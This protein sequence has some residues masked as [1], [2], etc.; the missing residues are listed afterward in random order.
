[1]FMNDNDLL[2][3][4]VARNTRP[5]I[6]FIV[7]PF[8]VVFLLA[9]LLCASAWA[10]PRSDASAPNTADYIVAVV[11]QELVTNGELQARIDRVRDDAARNGS[12]LPPPDELR[13]RALDALIDE[14]VQVTNARE[15]GPKLDEVDIDRAVANVATQNQMTLTQLRARLKQQGLSFATFRNNVKDQMLVERV[16]EREV[17]SRIRITDADVDAL[18]QQ[19]MAAAKGS[20]DLQIAQILTAVPDGAA[21]NVVAEKRAKAEA[22]LARVEA[23]TDFATVAHE[24]SDDTNRANGGDIGMRPADRLPDVFVAAVRDLEPGQVTTTLLQTGAGFHILKLVKRE[25]ASAFRVTQTHVRHILLR[26]SPE[27]SPE[28]A[29]RRLAEYRRQI[30]AGG[31]TFERVAQQVSEDA[32]APGGGDL[33]WVSPGSLVP[34]FETAMDA[35]PVDG[36]SDPVVSRFGVHLIQ[37]LGRRDV[38]LDVK[39]QR[40]QARNF[41]RAQK[42]ETAYQDWVKELRGRAYVEMREPPV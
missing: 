27:L 7:A 30:M 11:N 41:L 20:V 12:A 37:V 36:I 1:M 14:R 35:L 33:G 24:V 39:E 15:T 8:V 2:L 28:A 18:L 26:T 10:Q 21:A 19:R 38:D 40:E 42:F 6:R 22:A 16:R 31:T 29:T 23:G 9:S 34:E 13:K 17:N 3:Y 5:T 32:S 4:P 25:K